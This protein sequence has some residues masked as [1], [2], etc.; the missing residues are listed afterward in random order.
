MYVEAVRDL[1]VL[2]ELLPSTETS[3]GKKGQAISSAEKSLLTMETCALD[4]LDVNDIIRFH[5]GI[6]SAARSF[7]QSIAGLNDLHSHRQTAS[8]EEVSR[9]VT[10]HLHILDQ[11]A[12]EALGRRGDQLKV[13][14]SLAE[15]F[16]GISPTT[17]GAILA[18]VIAGR[19][20]CGTNDGTRC[21][22]IHFPFHN[23]SYSSR[24]NDAMES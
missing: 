10:H 24:Q 16:C 6:G 14:S 13:S 3:R 23:H 11:V 5:T 19:I 2:W 7:R 21:R 15:V 12:E 8:Q 4:D 18:P 17:A 9:A 20:T 1:S 22:H